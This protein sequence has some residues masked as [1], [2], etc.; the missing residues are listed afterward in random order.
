MDNLWSGIPKGSFGLGYFTDT[1]GWQIKYLHISYK[2]LLGKAFI[3][4]FCWL[5]LGWLYHNP[6]QT[7]TRTPPKDGVEKKMLVRF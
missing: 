3:E 7:K 6:K 5:C 4:N 1:S 2:F